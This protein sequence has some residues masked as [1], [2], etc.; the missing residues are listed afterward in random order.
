MFSIHLIS[1]VRSVKAVVVTIFNFLVTVVAAFACSYM[2]SQ[3]L[4][5]DTAAVGEHLILLVCYTP[6]CHLGLPSYMQY[7]SVQ[8]PLT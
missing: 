4:F 6:S 3:Y 2:G 1:P 7:S 8:Q 5:T